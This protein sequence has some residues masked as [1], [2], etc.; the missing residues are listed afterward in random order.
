MITERIGRDYTPNFEAQASAFLSI[1]IGKPVILR[2]GK[3]SV[4]GILLKAGNEYT[5]S[6]RAATEH[7]DWASAIFT[8]KDLDVLS[9]PAINYMND[10]SAV[11]LLTQR[12]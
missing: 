3:A 7:T 8:V 5:V 1:R 2:S 4:R 9:A 12:A 6:T 10:L 11:L